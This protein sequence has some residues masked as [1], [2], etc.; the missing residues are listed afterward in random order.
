M[1]YIEYLPIVAVF[2]GLTSLIIS[3]GRQYKKQNLAIEKLG[4]QIQKLTTSINEQPISLSREQALALADYYIQYNQAS[5]KE[6]IFTQ[7]LHSHLKDVKANMTR[8]VGLFEK[9]PKEVI[10]NS[11]N[12]IKIF[13]LHKNINFQQFLEQLDEPLND[14]IQRS[15]IEAASRLE[16]FSTIREISENDIKS[17]MYD[18]DRIIS[19][20]G[21]E[22]QTLIISQLKKLYNE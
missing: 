9:T 13:S 10:K 7:D 14:I 4:Y 8:I 11:R 6:Q 18:I 1:A 15:Q 3:Q 12:R 17:F 5:I 22:N 16:K 21:I 19:R 20:T 2:I